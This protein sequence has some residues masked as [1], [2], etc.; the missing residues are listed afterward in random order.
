MVWLQEPSHEIIHPTPVEIFIFTA[1]NR[2]VNSESTELLSVRASIEHR[3][4]LGDRQQRECMEQN[5]FQEE[6]ERKIIFIFFNFLFSCFAFS[7][8][9]VGK[10]I[11]GR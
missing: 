11:V 3:Y 6:W 10:N 5:P 2:H 7:L 9:M 8:E 4:L 1:E